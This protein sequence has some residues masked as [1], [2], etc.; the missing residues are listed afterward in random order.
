MTD[1]HRPVE[2]RILPSTLCALGACHHPEARENCP[3]GTITVCEPCTAAVVEPDGDPD[4][5]TA[6]LWPC[7]PGRH[8]VVRV[9]SPQAPAAGTTP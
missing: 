7:P 9:V 2:L 1:H 6:A 4:Y 8:L 3:T 5:V